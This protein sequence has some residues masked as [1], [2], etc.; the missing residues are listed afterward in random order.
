MS[1]QR[2]TTS[3]ATVT[4]PAQRAEFAYPFA[5]SGEWLKALSEGPM[6]FYG[7]LFELTAKQLRAQA[8]FMQGLAEG[9]N[10]AELFNR[11]VEFMQSSV[12]TYS[13][14]A[15]RVFAPALAA[16]GGLSRPNN[17]VEMTPRK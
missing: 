7:G 13:Q 15:S 10:P 14:E 3:G 8:D 1:A 2:A 6:N 17:A 16:I 4:A 9:G 5:A 11:Q 12:R